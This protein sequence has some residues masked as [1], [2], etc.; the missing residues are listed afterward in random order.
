MPNRRRL[1]RAVAEEKR[2]G[3]AALFP[4]KLG[5]RPRFRRQRDFLRLN[6][7]DERAKKRREDAESDGERSSR[8][9]RFDQRAVIIGPT[10]NKTPRIKNK[11]SKTT[12]YE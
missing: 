1:S 3:R 7:K 5:G 2:R 10:E 9:F 12:R 11:K 6:V 4:E 8:F